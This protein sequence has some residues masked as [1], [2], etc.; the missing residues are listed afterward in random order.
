M[1]RQLVLGLAV[2]YTI[3]IGVLSLISFNEFQQ[4]R[5]A[6]IDKLVHAGFHFI[7]TLI[8]YW[9]FVKS[10]VLKSRL[11]IRVRVVLMSVLYGVLIEA[12][13]H[14]LTT[15][16]Q[17]DYLDLVA[18]VVGACIALICVLIFEKVFASRLHK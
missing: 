1:H 4:V 2:L 14:L 13:Q 6:N 11:Q 9:Y 3:G 15:T 10:A 5:I 8:W 12:L 17:A 7:F 16:R 18:N